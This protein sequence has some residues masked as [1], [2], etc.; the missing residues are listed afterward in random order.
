MTK[1]ELELIRRLE[2]EANQFG[3]AV[4]GQYVGSGEALA[5][6]AFGSGDVVFSARASDTVLAFFV[7]SF[8]KPFHVEPDEVFEELDDIVVVS[9]DYR[10]R[11]MPVTETWETKRIEEAKGN[12]SPA[13]LRLE[14]ELIFG[15]QG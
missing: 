1:K 12:A 4:I 11:F 6:E 2:R 8:E 5:S 3:L 9:Q 10:L 15:E 13:S 14:Y 7:G